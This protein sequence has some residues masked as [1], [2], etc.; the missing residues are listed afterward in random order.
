MFVCGYS[1]DFYF[2]IAPEQIVK[3][4]YCEKATKFTKISHLFL[5]LLN[6]TLR[7][8]AKITETKLD[9]LNRTIILP[10]QKAN[11]LSNVGIQKH[12][13]ISQFFKKFFAIGSVAN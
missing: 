12:I 3:F 8:V 4:K 13:S 5:K 11:F 9:W 1:H 10:C 6:S 2:G 7:F